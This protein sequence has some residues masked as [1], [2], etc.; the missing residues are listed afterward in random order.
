MLVNP[1]A[2]LPDHSGETRAER[3]LEFVRVD[4]EVPVL[5]LREGSM[6]LVEGPAMTLLGDQ[7]ARVF[8][9]GRDP[10]EPPPGLPKADLTPGR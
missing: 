3:L 10:E 2:R 5:A 6:L 7:P 1:D 4:P 9:K 8:R